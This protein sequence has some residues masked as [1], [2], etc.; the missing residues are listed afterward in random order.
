MPEQTLIA[1]MLRASD[2]L[3]R[4]AGLVLDRLHMGPVETDWNRMLSERGFVLRRYANATPDAPPV[5]IV[6]APIKRPY[7]FDLLPPVSVVRRLQEKGFAVYLIEWRDAG[8]S[9][10]DCGLSEYAG[11]W[12]G[13]AVGAIAR[14]HG[15]KPVLV[16]HSLGGTF[17]A[18][19]AAAEPERVQ[20]LLLV[21]APLRFGPDTGAL[22]L[23]VG[24]SPP[25]G[26]V[27]NLAGGAPGSLLDMASTA[28]APGEF[29]AGRWQDAAASFLD[30]GAL[31]IHQRVI[32]WT[33]DEFAQP[34]RLFA[35][36]VELLYRGDAFAR[37][38]LR[39]ADRPVSPAGLAVLPI[40]VLIDETSRL[41][42]P[43]S[44]LGPLSN[45]DVY[46]YEPEVGVALQH[47]GPLVGRRAHRELWP[48]LADWMGRLT[49]P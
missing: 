32:R 8:D 14:R 28:G 1:S 16:G 19:F 21:E 12:L 34:P 5:L 20:K 45:P 40:A 27:A 35:E 47:V 4:L 31:S 38:T 6:P 11:T 29:I 39:L 33:L 49:S 30:W 36:T 9:G 10:A 2:G 7:I 46:F 42:P 26:L 44:A 37:G 24:A 3:R 43:A 17:A 41:V 23:V 15:R 22:A 25:A 48:R 18:I 13:S